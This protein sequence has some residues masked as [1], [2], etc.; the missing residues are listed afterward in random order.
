MIPLRISV[1]KINNT[2]ATLINIA[3]FYHKTKK[4]LLYFNFSCKKRE[5]VYNRKVCTKAYL[6]EVKSV[7]TAKTTKEDLRNG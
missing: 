6:W 1:K 3:S 2:E 4:S 7:I 5:I